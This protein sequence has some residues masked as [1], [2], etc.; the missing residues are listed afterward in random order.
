ME[1]FCWVC[2]WL[3]CINVVLRNYSLSVCVY[4]LST[5]RMTLGGNWN[6]L[7][8]PKIFLIVVC[9]LHE[10]SQ[11]MGRKYIAFAVLCNTEESKQWSVGLYVPREDEPQFMTEY[12]LY[13]R[14]VRPSSVCDVPARSGEAFI[15]LRK[16]WHLTE[17]HGQCIFSDP[18]V[19]IG[20]SS[21]STG[22]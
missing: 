5:Y 18:W 11:Q 7:F 6:P 2:F 19:G 4:V 22:R 21:A 3:R 10:Q 8:S 16:C 9:S 12:A 15:L 1:C 14:F 17:S 13:A 20:N